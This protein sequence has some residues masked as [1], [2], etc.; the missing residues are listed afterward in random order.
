V[1]GI[2][3]FLRR[4]H[5]GSRAPPLTPSPSPEP[6]Y[7]GQGPF[8]LP[9]SPRE[10]TIRSSS[11]VGEPRSSFL[12]PPT[13][14]SNSCGGSRGMTRS[15]NRCGRDPRNALQIP[16]GKRPWRPTLE[17]LRE[18]AKLRSMELGVANG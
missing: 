14:S 15:E 13:H 17:L 4:L 18:V 5:L 11:D 12:F 1:C 6:G 3:G 8:V 16:S 2:A 10:S 7:N 9:T